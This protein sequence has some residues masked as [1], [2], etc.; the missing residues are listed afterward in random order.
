MQKEFHNIMRKNTETWRRYTFFALWILTTAGFGWQVLQGQHTFDSQATL[1]ALLALLVCTVALLWWLP[2]PAQDEPSDVA[3]TR[4]GWFILIVVIAVGVLFPLRTLVG[5][6]LLFSLPVLAVATLALLR[7]QIARR[8]ML[9]ALGLALVAGVAGLGAGWVSFPPI[10]WAVLQV[11]LVL[12]GFLAGWSILR[13][14]GLLQVGIGRSRFLMEGTTSA[15]RGF[16]QGMLIG[17]PWALSIVVLG[18]SNGEN[19][20]HA[21]WQPVVAIQPGIAEE[22]W[23]RVFLVPLLF[24]ILR[25]VGRSRATFTAAVVI[26]GYWFAYL[27]TSG[28]LDAVVSTII[29]GTLYVLPTSYLCLHRDLETAIGFHFWLDFVKFAAAYLLNKGLWLS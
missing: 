1:P 4:R 14:S 13:D 7:P 18:G 11:L 12:T 29:I 24:L 20:V 17:M 21:W 15:L 3:R 25:R 23:G 5:P 10:V 8:E 28:G 9:Y 27:H 26:I 2:R 6:P 16:V 22:A 19:W